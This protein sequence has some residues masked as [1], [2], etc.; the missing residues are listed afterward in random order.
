MDDPVP[1]DVGEGAAQLQPIGTGFPMAEAITYFARAMGGA[2]SGNTAAAQA[3]IEKL[4]EQRA[5]LEKAGQGYWAGQVEIQ[6][7]IE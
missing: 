3:D 4:K 7:P 6:G 2:R 5:A 1:V